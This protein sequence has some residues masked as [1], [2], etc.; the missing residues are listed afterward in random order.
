MKV[1]L[2]LALLGVG[3]Y[4]VATNWEQLVPPESDTCQAAEGVGG[5]TVG[6]PVQVQVNCR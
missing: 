6:S 1:L 4:L 3:L 2:V 5:G